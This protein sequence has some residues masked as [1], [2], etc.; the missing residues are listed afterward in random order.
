MYG[1]ELLKG[2]RFFWILVLVWSA[3]IPLGIAATTPEMQS[4]VIKRMAMLERAQDSLQALEQLEEM[5]IRSLDK[6]K[7]I[8]NEPA[9]IL[10]K[11]PGTIKFVPP[12]NS[13]SA[14]CM[15]SLSASGLRSRRDRNVF[16][17]QGGEK[18]YLRIVERN[19]VIYDQKFIGGKS[20]P[21]GKTANPTMAAA[22]ETLEAASTEKLQQALQSTAYGIIIADD[23]DSPQLMIRSISHELLV[24]VLSR[25]GRL[26]YLEAVEHLVTVSRLEPV[27][28]LI[29][30]RACVCVEILKRIH[31]SP[32]GDFDLFMPLIKSKLRTVRGK[33]CPLVAIKYKAKPLDFGSRLSQE[34]SPSEVEPSPKIR[35]P[36]HP[37]PISPQ[38]DYPT[39][40]C[41]TTVCPTPDYP[42]P[43]YPLPDFPQRLD[44]K[45]LED[46]IQSVFSDNLDDFLQSPSAE[47]LASPI[48]NIDPDTQSDCGPQDHRPQT[49]DSGAQGDPA[50]GPPSPSQENFAE[51]R[52]PEPQGKLSQ[53]IGPQGSCLH[54][55]GTLG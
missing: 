31:F 48:Q 15:E 24:F 27:I 35:P 46:F 20:A 42:L 45:D 1:D 19:V 41:P 51:G 34:L 50:Q 7:S 33:G 13:P 39:A 55:P 47:P 52:D 53:G 6:I 8:A 54:V 14:E 12:V 29:I 43:D 18:F 37:T 22:R 10:V 11:N 2:P 23:N 40:D 38:P 28:V 4:T 30:P 49:L 16:M 5:R 44:P 17:N 25:E 36:N 32:L 3:T 21:R 9:E 26:W